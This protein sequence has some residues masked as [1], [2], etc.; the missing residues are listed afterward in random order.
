MKFFSIPGLNLCISPSRRISSSGSIII[1]CIYI[2]LYLGGLAGF[3]ICLGGSSLT[4]SNFTGALGGEI[5]TKFVNVE[6]SVDPFYFCFS[7]SVYTDFP[8][9]TA[10]TS[11]I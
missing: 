9:L 4:G 11:V 1:S 7:V 8:L 10:P 5:S 2:V 6:M 3:T